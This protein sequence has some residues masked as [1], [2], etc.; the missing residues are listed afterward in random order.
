MLLTIDSTDRLVRNTV[1]AVSRSKERI[2]CTFSPSALRMWDSAACSSAMEASKSVMACS[3]G[4][5]AWVVVVEVV[6]L[7]VV[8]VVVVV[9]LVVVVLVVVVLVVVL[10]VVVLVV[11]LVVVVLVVVLVVVVL[12]VVL[13][14][15]VVVLVVV[16][17]VVVVL[18]VLDVVNRQ[19]VASGSSPRNSSLW[20]SAFPE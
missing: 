6:V 18:V 13:L 16:V 17:L 9:V 7:D 15:V 10:V 5:G 2:F 1:S 8:V 4:T 19:A 3:R 11:V 20:L 12:V 14:V